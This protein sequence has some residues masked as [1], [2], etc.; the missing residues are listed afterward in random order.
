[1]LDAAVTVVIAALSGL[2]IITTRLN[3]RIS[4]LDAKVDSFAVKVAESYVTKTD[5]SEITDRMESHM[6][7]I[8]NKLDKLIFK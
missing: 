4:E 6:I 1:M 7:R 3:T 5:I 2:G 8:E